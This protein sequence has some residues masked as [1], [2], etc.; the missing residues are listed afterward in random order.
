[1]PRSRRGHIRVLLAAACAVL[2]IT[3]STL[4]AVGPAEAATPSRVG[5]PAPSFVRTV[6]D[7]DPAVTYTTSGVLYDM[8]YHLSNLGCCDYSGTE[9]GAY[10]LG[11]TASLTFTGTSITWWS[12]DPTQL[13]RA[14]VFI[15]NV[16]QATGLIAGPQPQPQPQLYPFPPPQPVPPTLR[17][18][19]ASHL[20]PTTHTIR[21]VMASISGIA[22]TVDAFTYTPVTVSAMDGNDTAEGVVDDDGTRDDPSQLQ[23]QP[24]LSYRGGWSRLTGTG[25]DYRGTESF[26]SQLDDTVTF[27]FYGTS[28][29]WW[30]RR[31]S[32]LGEAQVL[33]DW[34]TVATVDQ[35][36]P[37]PVGTLTQQ[38]IWSRTGLPM[39]WHTLQVRNLGANGGVGGPYLLVDALS[40]L[41]FTPA[42]TGGTSIDDQRGNGVAFD[43]PSAWHTGR[44][45]SG[46]YDGTE[47]STSIP[48]ATVTIPFVGYTFCVYGPVDPKH[49]AFRVVLDGQVVG[50]F[51][52]YGLTF[53]TLSNWPVTPNIIATAGTPLESR[54]ILQITALGS[55]S[56]TFS[57]DRVV[58]H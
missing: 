35:Y 54:H 46:S 26:T 5:V 8:W 13:A 45:R 32:N 21:I 33:L 6:D 56:A 3:G 12:R 27:T 2:A 58:V 38:E 47:T 19:T 1:V 44:G 16:E 11:D 39:G 36:S 23:L 29:S 30:G 22:I 48:G 55:G 18:F 24:T 9:S 43:P 28:V 34:Q 53:G 37:T 41:G 50:T 40:Y 25:S 20:S 31:Q 52:E 10:D 4:V 51:T 42:A 49:G 15:D 14:K 7:A 57:L 17:V